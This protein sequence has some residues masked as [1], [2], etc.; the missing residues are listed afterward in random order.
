MVGRGAAAA[1]DDVDE[2][3]LR[4]LAQVAARVARLLVVRAHLV[5][6]ARVRVA[7]DPGRRDSGEVLDERTH[8]A[9]AERA[10]DSDDEGVRVLDREP[11]RVHG[12]TRQV[13]AA[14]VD[15]RERDPERQ[16]GRRVLRRGD[17]RLGVEGVEDRLD[18]QEVDPAL[19]QRADLLRVH[20]AELIERVRPE[21]GIVDA[22]R[23][24]ERDV[25]RADGAG[26]EAVHLVRSLACEPC[27]LDVELAD[28]RLEAVVGLPDRGRREGVRRRDVGAGGEVLPVDVEHDLRPRDVEQVGI[29]GDIV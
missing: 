14:A 16:L 11:E 6:Q 27:P 26:D 25:E 22:R 23:Q 28:V 12:L 2:A 3:V 7:R 1:A 17:R 18:Q 9:C 19:G 21:R 4:E 8:L 5:R 20:L 10:V 15:R 24:R 13:A 29:A